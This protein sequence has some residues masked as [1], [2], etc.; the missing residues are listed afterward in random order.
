[1]DHIVFTH[2]SNNRH[3]GCVQPLATVNHVAMTMVCKYLSPCFQFFWYVL[4]VG[5]QG[6]T[7]T[8]CLTFSLRWSFALVAQAGVQR[9][10]LSS[11]QPPPPGFKRFSRLNLPSS[12]DHRCPPPSLANFCIF[13]RDRVLPCWPSWSQIP[14]LR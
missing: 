1:M 13:S 12:W 4:K 9:C 3:L 14:D 7:V 8:L 6:H 2:P 11:L 5:F 10:G